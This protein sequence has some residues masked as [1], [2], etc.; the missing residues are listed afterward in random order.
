MT[1]GLALSKNKFFHKKSLNKKK[2]YEIHSPFKMFYANKFASFAISIAT[3]D[4]L[5]PLL[6]VYG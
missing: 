4:V 6:N 2:G 1:G 5:A 3:R